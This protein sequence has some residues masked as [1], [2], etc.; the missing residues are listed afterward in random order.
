MTAGREQSALLEPRG[1]PC[2][3]DSDDDDDD[4]FPRTRDETTRRTHANSHVR[5]SIY[6][7]P[8]DRRRPP[9]GRVLVTGHLPPEHIRPPPDACLLLPL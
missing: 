8:G 3:D 6:A 4:A 2:D 5:F 1:W 9:A 7:R